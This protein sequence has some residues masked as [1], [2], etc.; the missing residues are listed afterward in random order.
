MFSGKVRW[1]AT[2][3]SAQPNLSSLTNFI[4]F[5][6]DRLVD[7]SVTD[8]DMF[9]LLKDHFIL[10]S[11][12]GYKWDRQELNS[13]MSEGYG[14]F[15]VNKANAV[16]AKMYLQLAKLPEVDHHLTAP[17]R[18]QSI[19]QMGA[20]FIKCLHEGDITPAAVVKA[21]RL[22]E[23]IV[24]CLGEDKTAIQHLSGLADRDF[25]TYFHSIRVSTYAVAIAQEMGVTDEQHLQQIALG[26]IFHDIGKKNVPSTLINKAGPLTQEE[27]KIMRSHPSQGHD[28]VVDSILTHIP[29]EIVLHHH[30]KLSGNGY[31]HGLDKSSLL[32]EVQIATLADIFDALTSTRSY[33][34]KRSRYEALDFIRHKFM[35]EINGEAY[36]ALISCLVGTPQPI[37]A[38]N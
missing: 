27:W 29:R 5:P 30:E 36:K 19:E 15:Y 13:L 38:K 31:P 11:P 16:Q 10:Y 9:I 21:E 26:G 20:D 3:V 34:N 24:N 33:Q 6:V 25:Y 18:I 1:R 8:F 7:N 35:H 22:A 14:H 2:Q 28:L 23:S 32:L 17:D 4:K 37:E 12:P